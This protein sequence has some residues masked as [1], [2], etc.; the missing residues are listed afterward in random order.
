MTLRHVLQQLTPATE[1]YLQVS[2]FTSTSATMFLNSANS[3]SA[4]KLR[5]STRRLVISFRVS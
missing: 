1:P 3:K 5:V 2:D 4:S